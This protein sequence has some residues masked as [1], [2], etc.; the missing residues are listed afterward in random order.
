MKDDRTVREGKIYTQG[1]KNEH[2]GKRI[3]VRRR[4]REMVSFSHSPHV[5]SFRQA[6]ERKSDVMVH[7]HSITGGKAVC[8]ASPES[9]RCAGHHP[10]STIII[11]RVP[12]VVS[13][14]LDPH[15]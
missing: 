6:K 3:R 5:G 1:K 11:N 14:N 10:A 9:V 12:R 4:I 2:L 13:M 7:T 15:S 8:K